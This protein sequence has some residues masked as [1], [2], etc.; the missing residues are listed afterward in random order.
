MNI[1]HKYLRNN[2][3]FP[4]LWCPGCGNGI[5]LGAV[6]RAIDKLQLDK[7]EVVIVSG[8]GCSGRSSTYVDFHTVHTPHGRALTFATGIKLGSMINKDDLKVIVLMGDGDALS[9]GGNHFI[10]ACRRAVD[11]TAVVFNNSVYGMTGGQKSPTS[12]V[13]KEINKRWEEFEKPLSVVDIA[14][15][16]GAEY[17]ARGDVYHAVISEK[18][19]REGI[20]F[21][22]FAVIEMLS[23]CPTHMKKNP[24]DMLNELKESTTT[25]K[26]SNDKIVIGRIK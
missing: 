14:I 4:H 1:V 2:K 21:P 5:I 24:V 25:D 13:S 9:M 22:G 20:S 16:S 17:V 15:A 10:H 3:I 8:I 12:S 19:I 26:N 11:I 7:N 23:T 6:I 18:L